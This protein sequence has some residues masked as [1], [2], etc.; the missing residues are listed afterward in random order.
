MLF[1]TLEFALFAPAVLALYWLLRKRAPQNVLL[2][3]ASYLFYAAWDWRFLSL[4]MFQSLVDYVA[5]LGIGGSDDER[6]RKRYLVAAITINLLILAVFKYFGFFV[7]SAVG[8]LTWFGLDPNPPLLEV[9]LPIGI[10]FYTFQSITYSFDV[11]R[12]RLAPT[13]NL[14]NYAVFVAY[15]PHM[16]AGPIQRANHLLPQ[17]ESPRTLPT[18]DEVRSGLFLIL[19]GIFKKVAIADA[20]AGVANEAFA[21]SGSAG[22]VTLFVGMLAFSLQIYGDFAGY[23]DVARGVSRLFGIELTRNFEQPYLSRNITEFWRTWHISLSSWLHDYLY[24]PLGGNKG[25]KIIT[26]R[27]LM[28]T[29]LLGGLWHGASWTFVV[30][31][32]LHGLLLSVHRA[33]GGNAPRGAVPLPRGRDI[34]RVLLTFGAVSVL[35]IFFRAA[36]LTQALE[37]IAG[38]FSFTPG[39]VNP[40][41]VVLV[42]LAAALMLTLD[43]GQRATGDHSMVLRWRPAL[44]GAACAVLLLAIVLWSGGQAQPFIYFQF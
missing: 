34:P 35:W 32:G 36:T 26:Y 21:S 25:S 31:G 19:M 20:V 44:R 11:Y 29:M 5:G 38:M 42:V 41:H 22:S 3:I 1:N 7:D 17:I 9:L 15:F 14:L 4:L 23:S 10:S 40:D 30:W 39:A 6:T 43:L 28:L 37:Y 24:V 18:R 16:V 13:R 8:I 33:F 2:L 12:R 27:N